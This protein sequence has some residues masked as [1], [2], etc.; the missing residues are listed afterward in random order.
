MYIEPRRE[1]GRFD[2]EV[3]L[4]LKDFEPT[5]SRGGDM[6]MGFLLPAATDA[7]L[8]E[9]GESAM[10][11]S[12]ERGLPHG[13]EV[14]YRLL[15]INGRML[16]HGELGR[17][18]AGERVLFHVLTASATEIRSLVLP[19]NAF[20][21]V[22]LDGNPVPTP[23]QVPALWI[24]T[25]ERVSAIVEMNH[26][27]VWILGDVDDDDRAHGMGIVV[28]YAGAKGTPQ[29]T[30]L[31]SPKWDYTRFGNGIARPPDETIEML[32]IK[33]NAAVNGFN[34]WTINGTAF[35]MK[36]M[37]PM[38]GRPSCAI[39]IASV[40]SSCRSRT[41][42]TASETPR[43]SGHPAGLHCARPRDSPVRKGQM[44]PPGCDGSRRER[45]RVP[46]RSGRPSPPPS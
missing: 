28:E 41:P 5:L 15:S 16:G 45:K 12:L 29:W 18:K 17:V 31:V 7:K 25:A 46:P 3:V 30:K 19:G 20:T 2:R 23:T 34:Q 1:P 35:S 8:K 21:V 39:R 43:F 22:A 26:P 13:Y 32:F 44:P 10:A 9:A 42:D 40:L 4:V 14:G 6:A 11:A 37:R 33:N 36:E 27:G 38:F 24:G